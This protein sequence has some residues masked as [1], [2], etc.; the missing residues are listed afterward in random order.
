MTESDKAA[1]DRLELLESKVEMIDQRLQRIEKALRELNAWCGE[2]L[3]RD[4]QKT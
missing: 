4:E 1:L 3:K 2:L